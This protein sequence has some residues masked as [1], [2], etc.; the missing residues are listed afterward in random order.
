MAIIITVGKARLSA[1]IV[2]DTTTPLGIGTG[3]HDTLRIFLNPDNNRQVA[4]VGIAPSSGVNATVQLGTRTI[5]QLFEVVAEPG[6]GDDLRFGDWSDE[7]E[8]PSWAQ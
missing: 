1:V 8:P 4:V 3:N 2:A 5:A 7:V 6:P